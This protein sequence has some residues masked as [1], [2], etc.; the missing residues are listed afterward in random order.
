MPLLCS[1]FQPVGYLTCSILVKQSSFMHDD[2]VTTRLGD[3]NSIILHFIT[4]VGGRGNGNGFNLVYLETPFF[5]NAFPI[6]AIDDC[7]QLLWRDGHALRDCG[8]AP[9]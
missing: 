1:L 7:I 3:M 6:R 9:E 2:V 5:R 8:L 4:G